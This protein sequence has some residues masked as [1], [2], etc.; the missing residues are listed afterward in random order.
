MAAGVGLG[1][2]PCYG[3]ERRAEEGAP[4]PPPVEHPAVGLAGL[5]VGSQAPL[6]LTPAGTRGGGWEQA[7]LPGVSFGVNW[8]GLGTA[9]PSASGR[10]PSSG[11]GRSGDPSA[12]TGCWLCRSWAGF[13]T[14][15]GSKELIPDLQCWQS[16]DMQLRKIHTSKPVISFKLSESG[17]NK[18][19]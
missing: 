19:E 16:G 13:F 2:A 17:R 1:A 3:G 8:S 10:W 7:R 11:G 4:S 5:C 6:V 14:C 9:L 15:R 18:R 12:R